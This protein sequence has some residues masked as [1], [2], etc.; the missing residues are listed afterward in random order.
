MASNH[1][2]T[3]VPDE[4]PLDAKIL[5]VGEAPG[6]DEMLEG[7][8]FIGRSGEK[9]IT[10]LSNR[11]IDR[12]EV[13]LAN[14]CH[15]RPFNNKFEQLVGTDVLK[16]G[17]GELHEYIRAHRPTLIVP[18][19]TWPLLFLT[20]K[21]GIKKYRGSILSYI[22]DETI[23]VIPTFH[24]SA[25]L[26]KQEWYPIFSKDMERIVNDSTFPEKRLPVREYI[27]NPRG[28]LCEEWVQRLC[29]ARELS[30][31]IESVKGTT[32]I[33]CVGFA[34]SPSIGV[35]FV[36]TTDE[37]RSAIQRIL[38]SNARKIFQNGGGFDTIMMIYENGYEI[39]D[40]EAAK[41]NRPYYWDTMVA[42]HVIAPEL[43]L[44]LEYMTSVRTREPY[45]KDE[46]K[47]GMKDW[48]VK[49]NRENLYVYNCKDCCCT[50]EVYLDQVPDINSNH[51][52]RATFDYEMQMLI[53]NRHISVTGLPI[54]A[55]RREELTAFLFRKWAYL[56]FILDRLTGYETNV[57]SPRLKEILYD[58]D[59]LGLPTRRNRDSGITTDED[60]IV[61]LITYCKDHIGKL[62]RTDAISDWTLKLNVL[63]TI[64]EIRGIRQILSVYLLDGKKSTKVSAD[65]RLRSVYKITTETGRSS[66]SKY[67]DGTGA[68]AQT[69]PRDPIVVPASSLTIPEPGTILK[70]QMEQDIDEVENEDDQEEAA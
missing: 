27:T 31:D 18:L 61:S 7:R 42:E 68:N 64:L 41:L 23:K 24:P 58:K 65:G 37:G 40:P 21:K 28:I 44:S 8:P 35:C 1:Y 4:G 3:Y 17:V 19:G 16:Q 57:R 70:K 12:S 55:A 51:N 60:A 49:V 34:P 46:G 48:S 52:H 9:L 36:P 69:F 5:F 39:Y 53:P 14:L 26:R 45:Y 50:F 22:H 32:H 66:C 33:L 10:T 30:V 25:V 20:G 59:K 67:V 15:Y 2:D 47:E 13:R 62:V 38:S 43:Q 6:E 29:N 11:G 54:D 56:Q 63:K